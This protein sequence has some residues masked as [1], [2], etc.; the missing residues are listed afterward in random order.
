[1]RTKLLI[2]NTYLN[3]ADETIHIFDE[4]MDN[5][6]PLTSEWKHLSIMYANE[7]ACSTNLTMYGCAIASSTV[8]VAG[9]SGALFSAWPTSAV[10]GAVWPRWGGPLAVAGILAGLAGCCEAAR[11][12]RL[13]RMPPGFEHEDGG[14][15]NRRCGTR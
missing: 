7:T 4:R 12:E 13:G 14:R 6:K 3:T 8:A 5:L 1:M 2:S 9:S 11:R 15:R 10:A